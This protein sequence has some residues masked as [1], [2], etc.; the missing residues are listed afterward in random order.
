MNDAMIAADTQEEHRTEAHDFVEMG[1][2][3]EETKGSLGGDWIDGG[4]GK[5]NVG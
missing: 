3:S 1:K 5:W 4:A 2:V